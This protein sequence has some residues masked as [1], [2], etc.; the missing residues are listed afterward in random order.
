MAVAV[1]VVIRKALHAS[2]HQIF[3]AWTQAHQVNQWLFFSPHTKTKT[4]IDFRVKGKYSLEMMNEGSSTVVHQGEYQIIIPNEKIIFTWELENSAREIDG[5]TVVTV[6]FEDS[7]ASTQMV[8]IH[9]LLPTEE[10]RSQYE[11]DWRTALVRL[12]QFLMGD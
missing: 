12:E 9:Q 3:D 5:D 10:L 7:G 1:A 11:R 6:D 4:K 8:L 2:R